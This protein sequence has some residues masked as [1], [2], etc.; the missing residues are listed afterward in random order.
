MD[1]VIIARYGE[2]HLKGGNRGFF[3]KALINNL[4]DKITDLARIT[5]TEGRVII[6]KYKNCDEQVVLGS[7]LSTFGFISASIVTSVEPTEVAIFEYLRNLKIEGSFKIQ[8]NRANKGFPVKSMD[9]AP[10]CGEVILTQA[11]RDKRKVWV[12][13]VNPATMIS[14]DIRDKAYIFDKSLP[15]LGGL[16]VG[17]SGRAISLLSG[18]IDSPVA[19][20]LA[21]KRGLCVD[22]IHFATPPYTSDL[23]LEKI[24]KLQS[25]IKNFCGK[26]RLFIVPFTEISR[27][28]KKSCSE[29]FV[30]TLMRRF[31]VRIAERLGLAHGASCIITGEN[32]AQV[33][34]QTVEGIRSNN[35]VATELP[36]LRP[37]VTFDKQEII[38]LAKR[39]G[40]YD[41]SIEPHLD[42]CTIFVPKNPIIKPNLKR[43]ETEEQKIGDLQ[44][45]VDRAIGGV[46]VKVNKTTL[47]P[48]QD[49]L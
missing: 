25:V 29:E 48:R 17:V 18:G 5:F 35:F 19:T 38:A 21:A 47:S 1:R 31:M 10:V 22:L 20:L 46:E 23:A 34:S 6:D 27:A 40:T 2:I 36:I 12:D 32:L 37:L 45:L 30:I 33:A 28:I 44:D 15:A 39:F 9:F 26:V 41:V 24:Y 4:K 42:C 7:V 3:I 14:I 43:V 49:N 11:E 8:I 16:P 13:V